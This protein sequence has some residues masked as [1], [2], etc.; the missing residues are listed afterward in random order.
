MADQLPPLQARVNPPAAVT[1][2]LA[3][4]HDACAAWPKTT[5]AKGQGVDT[6]EAGA[7]TFVLDMHGAATPI[8]MEGAAAGV[9]G[10]I[11]VGFVGRAMWR[12]VRGVIRTVHA[13]RPAARG[14]A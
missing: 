7:C 13:A 11:V 10:A 12:T 4:L 9:V 3:S 2:A 14:Q 8:L 5:P 1:Q 6:A